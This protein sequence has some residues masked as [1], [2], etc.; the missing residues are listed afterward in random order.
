M[1]YFVV[2]YYAYGDAGREY[3]GV[4]TGDYG[5]AGVEYGM[6]GQFFEQRV[7]RVVAVPNQRAEAF[8]MLD[9]A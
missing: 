7:C 3:G 8:V 1:R 6:S 2:S 4:S 5:V 9:F